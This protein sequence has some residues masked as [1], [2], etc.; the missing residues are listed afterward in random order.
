MKT[1]VK[2]K[3]TRN[4][5]K[6]G[7]TLLAEH[8]TARVSNTTKVKGGE[9]AIH[10]ATA[11]SLVGAGYA[12][13]VEGGIEITD[14]GRDRADQFN[15]SPAAR[16]RRGAQDA[17]EAQASGKWKPTP[18]GYSARAQDDL[19]WAEREWGEVKFLVAQAHEQVNRVRR[20]I[21]LSKLWGD[22]EDVRSWEADLAEAEQ[23]LEHAIR[24]RDAL[25]RQQKRA[26]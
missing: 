24:D 16:K 1:F 5:D 15:E 21:K 12:E 6:R 3:T 17:L 19:Y 10:S 14:A 8:G 25:A 11:L 22:A 2:F 23:Q 20:M 13:Q 26:A 7:L 4:L 18:A 9:L